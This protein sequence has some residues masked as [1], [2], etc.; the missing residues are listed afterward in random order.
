MRGKAAS[1]A[2]GTRGGTFATASPGISN[3]GFS[4]PR[5]HVAAPS[6]QLEPRT[7][8]RALRPMAP[9]AGGLVLLEVSRVDGN[10][11]HLLAGWIEGEPWAGWGESIPCWSRI[12]SRWRQRRSRSCVALVR[13][14]C[15]VG[16][17]VLGSAIARAHAPTRFRIVAA[18]A[19]LKM[20]PPPPLGAPAVLRMVGRASFRAPLVLQTK[21]TPAVGAPAVLG[22]GGYPGSWST[23]GARNRWY[24]G[25]WSTGRARN[26]GYPGGWSP[27][28]AYQGG[29]TGFRGLSVNVG[30]FAWSRRREFADLAPT[31]VGS[32]RGPVLPPAPHPRG[33]AASACATR[34][35]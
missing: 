18:P 31:S 29:L 32:S 27:G 5:A 19:V 8:S 15:R 21:G 14:D 7:I 1:K 4:N 13:L 17:R 34:S 30:R 28:R 24:P 2:M 20:V 6:P 35:S 12:S 25:S 33:R 3:R 26:G 22:T 11:P 23:S 10:F 9:G 16:R